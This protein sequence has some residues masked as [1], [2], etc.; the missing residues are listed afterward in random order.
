MSGLSGGAYSV[1]RVLLG[2]YLAVHFLQLVPY[3]A[4]VFSREGVLPDPAASPFG[5]LFPNP[6]AWW[7]APWVVQSLLTAGI[8]AS[9]ALA[10]GWRDRLAAVFLW[11]LWAWLFGRNP[12]I[13]NPG[14]PYVGL[15]LVVHALLPPAP[16]GSLAARDRPDPGG[17]W[18]MDPGLLRV[19]WILMAVG[20]SYSGIT[21]LGSPS[22]IDG[23]AVARVLEN[24]LARPG[25]VRD[26]L[27]ALPEG[28]L[29][30]CTWGALFLEVAFAPLALFRRTRP[31]IWLAL[32]CMHLN[33]ILVIDFADLSLGMLLLHLA[34]FD[35]RWV[36]ARNRAAGA[37]PEIVFYDG[38]CGLCH[39][40]IRFLLAEDEEASFGLAPLQG[41][42]LQT[43]LA[44]APRDP[45][46]DSIVVRTADER[47]LT[48][49]AAVLYLGQRL[50]GLWRVLATVAGWVP[51]PLRD[52][53][54]RG[55]ARVRRSLFA[56]PEGLCPMVPPTLGRRFLP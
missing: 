54:Y 14:L 41:E 53:V 3:G 1:Y 51:G 2:A 50:G 52:A 24:P 47:W 13:S 39:R 42:T 11:L 31:W 10:L 46:P 15:L 49:S 33:L 26:A 45:L 28:I 6:L 20:Y 43:E 9:T 44:A 30:A 34:T 37:S 7:D 5:R 40:A 19:L 55:I 56:K 27:L 17:G 16:Y 25:W 35:P 48:H 32:L 12:L 29:R 23:S 18:R 21:K 4:E 22:W 8:A 36:P 38:Q